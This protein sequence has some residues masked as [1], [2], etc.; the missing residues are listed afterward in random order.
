MSLCN[1]FV[2]TLKEDSTL[3]GVEGKVRRSREIEVC[4]PFGENE[5]FQFLLSLEFLKYIM[6]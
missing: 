6:Y 3:S 2:S 4:K 1:N 5:I